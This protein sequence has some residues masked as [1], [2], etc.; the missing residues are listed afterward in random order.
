MDRP[1]IATENLTKTYALGN[2]EVPALRRISLTLEQGEFAS[3]SGPSGSGK[4]T[5]LNLLGLLDSPSAGTLAF[6]GV[7]MHYRGGMDLHRLRLEKIGFIFQTFNLIPVLTA[8]ENVE[9]PLLLTRKSAAQRRESVERTLRAVKLW[10]FR[11]HKPNEMSGG[12]RQRVAIARAL[13]NDPKLVLADEP[14]ANIDSSTSAEILDLMRTLN[15]EEKV[16]FLF[17]TH[18]PVVVSYAK[19][20]LKIHDGMLIN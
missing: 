5:L 3:L 6:D 14:T 8:Y 9:Y 13:V 7:S 2:I 11:K 15:E 18:D 4:T 12:Q 1:L 20:T 17:S 16:T 19:R 10:D